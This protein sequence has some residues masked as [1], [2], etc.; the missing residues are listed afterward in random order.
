[1]LLAVAEDDAIKICS[2]LTPDGKLKE[3]RRLAFFG[4]L[5]FRGVHAGGHTQQGSKGESGTSE[6]RRS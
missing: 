6:L 3:V 1:M 4:G 2:N 5:G